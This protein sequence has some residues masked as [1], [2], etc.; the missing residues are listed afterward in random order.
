MATKTAEI[1]IKKIAKRLLDNSVAAYGEAL[2]PAD[3]AAAKTDLGKKIVPI[4]QKADF[5]CQTDAVH[6]LMSAVCG[7]DLGKLVKRDKKGLAI[8]FAASTLIV[9]V[10]ND[11][12]HDYG[13][14]KCVFVFSDGDVCRRSN[15][16]TGNH[17][18]GT[19]S[20]LRLPTLAEAEEFVRKNLPH[21]KKLFIVL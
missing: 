15:W 21:F 4:L 6:A 17:L 19:A 8:K 12:A 16:T 7:E 10:K 1:L 9:P 14:G 2:K 11:N 3:K 20:C 5:G 18:T 13:L